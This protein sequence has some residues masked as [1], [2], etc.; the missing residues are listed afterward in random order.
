MSNGTAETLKV[1]E[2]EISMFKYF[3]QLKALQFAYFILK[4]NMVYFD[5]IRI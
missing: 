5:K 2:I 1:L 3:F 4:P